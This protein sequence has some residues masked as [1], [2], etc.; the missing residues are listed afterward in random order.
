MISFDEKNQESCLRQV[1]LCTGFIYRYYHNN[2]Q[3]C[4]VVNQYKKILKKEEET[5]L[6]NYE[7]IKIILLVYSTNNRSKPYKKNLKN[8]NNRSKSF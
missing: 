3:L 2:G 8:T 5:M 6:G 1:S 4:Q 7:I